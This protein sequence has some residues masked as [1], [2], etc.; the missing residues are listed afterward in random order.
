MTESDAMIEIKGLSGWANLK[1]DALS[2]WSDKFDILTG[3]DDAVHGPTE[4]AEHL[5]LDPMIDSI[6]TLNLQQCW[7]ICLSCASE[8]AERSVLCAWHGRV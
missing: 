5:V 4:Q 1:I 7:P 6:C 8:Y 3:G 2:R